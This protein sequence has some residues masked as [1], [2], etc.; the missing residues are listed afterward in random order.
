MNGTLREAIELFNSGENQKAAKLFA[1]LVIEQPYN[2]SAWY[3]LALC[4]EDTE[5]Q[6]YCLQK[7]LS[8]NPNHTNA[9]QMIGRLSEKPD[10][11]ECP[12]CAASILEEAVICS[13][14]GRDLLVGVSIEK[15][16]VD[17]H[18][19]EVQP[20]PLKIKKQPVWNA[21]RDK[22]GETIDSG[23]IRGCGIILIMIGV[24]GALIYAIYMMEPSSLETP[25]EIV[26][27]PNPTRTSNPTTVATNPDPGPTDISKAYT[28]TANPNP[29][30]N[31]DPSPSPS[32]ITPPYF[33]D[34]TD[35]SGI[36][37]VRNDDEVSF[38]VSGG[39]YVIKPKNPGGSWW[40]SPLADLDNIRLEFTS[41][42][43]Y[44]YPMEDGGFRVNFRCVDTDEEDCYKMFV[45]E[46]GYI[47]VHRD[48]TTLVEHRLSQHI[49]LYDHLN[50]WVIVMDGSDF[51][52]HCNG[53][54]LTT[55]SDSKYKSGDFGFGVFNS[56]TNKWGF[57]GVAFDNVRVSSLE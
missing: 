35:G 45:S 13:N 56:E 18:E 51:E 33:E 39:Q 11:K 1:A 55:F 32:S 31:P 29:V 41:S 49:N 14:C 12:Y 7:V 20:E 40:T 19:P 44:T 25:E 22:A 30:T 42:F 34:F 9:R 8:I 6:I 27:A 53:E 57:N 3:G 16:Q 47:Y 21:I 54:L 52:I 37:H 2:A 36:W 26:Y 50:E 4:L 17:V 48:E 5:K 15:E 38:E 10:T 43:L 24:L 23:F 28:D 46:N